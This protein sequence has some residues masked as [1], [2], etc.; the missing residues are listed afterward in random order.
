MSLG[1]MKEIFPIAGYG[2][3]FGT[4]TARGLIAQQGC[5]EFPA[6]QAVRLLLAHDER[7]PLGAST[8]RR[9]LRFWQDDY[10]LAFE[11]D[12]PINSLNLSAIRNV[13][14]RT[15]CA[16][17]V[18]YS[19]R[20]DE[21]AT[22]VDGVSVDLIERTRIDEISIVNEGA[23]PFAWCWPADVDTRDLPYGLANIVEHWRMRR[24][25]QRTYPN[26][27]PHLRVTPPDHATAVST[28]AARR[29]AGGRR[30]SDFIALTQATASSPG[31]CAHAGRADSG[32]LDR[33]D[34]ILATTIGFRVS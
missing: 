32:L 30:I 15:M 10:G 21:V 2:A 19:P 24:E 26:L 4:L 33:I 12:L 23:D 3:T 9:T 25:R 29:S 1:I 18:T 20:R 31:R 27:R 7:V 22:I 5:F 14:N 6:W 13:K 8:D 17:S 34:H 28:V 11:A 16:I